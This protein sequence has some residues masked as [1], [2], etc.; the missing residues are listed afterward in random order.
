MTI[1]CGPTTRTVATVASRSAATCGGC[2]ATRSRTR[3]QNVR[4]LDRRLEVA[5]ESG[6]DDVH[7]EALAKTRLAERSARETAV[8]RDPQLDQFDVVADGDALVHAGPDRRW[9]LLGQT[10]TQ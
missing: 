6:P 7:A 4:L 3:G 5:V 2:P 9:H 8:G 1:R 10:P